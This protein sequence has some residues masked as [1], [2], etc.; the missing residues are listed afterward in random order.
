MR[1]VLFP[2]YLLCTVIAQAQQI[3]PDSILSRSIRQQMLLPQEKLYIHT[4]KPSY[5]AGEKVWLRAHAVDGVTHVLTDASRYVYVELWNPF[6]ELVKRVKLMADDGGYIYGH[7]PLPEN[8]PTGEYTLYAYTRYMENMGRDYFFNKKLFVNNVL[9]KSVRMKTHMNGSFLYVQFFNPATGEQLDLKGCTAQLPSGEIDVQ[10]SDIDFR[11]KIHESKEHMLLIQ[12]GNYKEFVSIASR[13]HYDVAFLPEGGHLPSGTLCRVAFKALNEQ[14][15]G[16]DI[17]GTLMDSRDS[18]VT[19][20]NST[21]R[22][23]GVLSFIPKD[24]EKYHAVCRDAEGR[25]R[26]FDF[27]KADAQALTLQVNCVKDKIY[28]KVLHS[29]DMITTDSLII[30][31]HQR[32]MARH[33][34]VW[35][36]GI[37]YLTFDNEDFTS[38]SVSVLLIN[39]LGKIVS[40]R[41]L[42]I[43]GNDFARGE[44]ISDATEYGVREKMTLDLQVMDAQGNPWNGSCSV[45]VT[46]NHD[47]QPDSCTNIL[48]TLLLTSDL[49]GYIEEPAWYFENVGSAK[50]QQALDVLMMT[51]GWKRYDWQQVWSGE[52]DTISI[53]P[54]RSQVITGRVVNRISRNPVKNAKV[55]L[56]STSVGMSGELSTGEA[57]TFR[58]MG[59]D[60]PDSTS[61][62]LSALTARG[63]SNIV[64][65]TDSIMYPSVGNRLPPYRPRYAGTQLN[66][67]SARYLEKADLRILQENGIRH[68]F[69]DEVLVTAPRKVYGTVYERT[70]GASTIKEEELNRSAAMDVRTLLRQKISG[71]VYT[72]MYDKNIG[73]YEAYSMRGNSILFILDD[74]PLN[75]P[76][77]NPSSEKQVEIWMKSFPVRDIGQIDVIKGPQAIGFHSKTSN[78]IAFTTKRGDEMQNGKWPVTNLKTIIPLGFQ[79]PVEFYSPKYDT[80]RKKESKEPDLRTTIYWQPDVV[81]KDGKAQIECY[82]S[83]SSVDYTVVME[84]VGEDGTLLHMKKRIGGV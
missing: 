9:N 29:P 33:I 48:S 37:P 75:P 77:T 36:Q 63:K 55:T 10:R 20:F 24:G 45:A 60:C 68:L 43:H 65:E 73:W 18:V 70:I 51:Q 78:I 39:A 38:G 47:I 8:L 28:A 4:D 80:A 53:A 84:G 58:F 54:E 25:E 83:D 17:Q 2:L 49:K 31:T 5:I 19:H 11:I 16:E 23:M 59:F 57:G 67:L 1:K 76:P 22:G 32:G 21:H 56:I 27:P 6:M 79:L 62:W 50:R 42:F 41:M 82:T 61:F 30:F 64:L 15:Q 46:D 81:V 72:Q 44:T 69:M 40:E 52:Y 26:R 13:P 7:I 71:F 66:T 12:T 14:G 35:K 34:G 74:V 3:L